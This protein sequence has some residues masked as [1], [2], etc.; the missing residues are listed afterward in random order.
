M[1]N[2]RLINNLTGWAVLLLALIVYTLTLEPTA[3]FWDSGEFIAASYK[4]QIPH[5][6][7]PPFF[8]LL[9][10][11]FS[12]FAFGDVEMIAFCVNMLSATSSAFAVMFLY[13]SIVLV[14][15][16]VLK[17]D[18]KI[19]SGRD[20]FLLIGSGI[21]G[22]LAFA[23]S[24]SFW[25]SA[26]EAEVYALSM[27]FTSIAFWAILR[28]DALKNT[29]AS[30]RWLL[31]IA[32]LMGLSIGV[33][34]MNLLTIPSLALIYYY[35]NY[36]F[37]WKGLAT[38][39]VL[40]GVGLLFVMFGFRVG[41][42]SLLARME[43]FSVN[44]LGLGF[45]SGAFFGIVLLAACVGFGLYYSQKRN[46]AAVNTLILAASFLVIGY[47]SF[48]LLTIRSSKNPLIDMGN[49]ENLPNFISYLDMKQY[50]TR[51]LLH[52]NYFDAKVVEQK[53]DTPVYTKEAKSYEITDYDYELTYDPARTTV[54]PRLWSQR[55]GHPEIYR[56]KLGLRNG[57]KPS[58]TDN[59][60]FLFSYQLGHM[61]M[62]YF[63]W[64]F[65]GRESDVQ[66]A[67]WI[68]PLTS[69]A[70]VVPS[71]RNNHARNNYLMLPLLLGLAGLLFS[72][73]K[74]PQ[75]FSVIGMLFLVTG[76]GLVLY[77]NSPPVEPRERDY[78][79]VGSFFAFSVWIGLGAL[80]VLKSVREYFGEKPM[81]SAVAWMITLFV[82][83]ILISQNWNDHDRSGRYYTTDMAKNHLASCAPNGILFTGGDNDTY[84][85]WY[86][87][88]V[89]GVRTDVRVIVGSLFS[90]DW[91]IEMM[92]RKAYES[93]PL[94]FSIQKDLYKQGGPIDYVPVVEH[95]SLK[96]GAVDLQQYLS[97]LRKKHQAIMVETQAGSVLASIPSRELRIPVNRAEVLEK[98]LVPDTM[99]QFIPDYLSF[100][101]KG[102]GLQKSEVMLLDLIASN[103]WERPI[104]FTFTAL[105]QLPFDLDK[106]VVQEGFT[107]RLLPVENPAN[108]GYLVHT[109]AMYENM[110]EKY[111][112]RNLA[113]PNVNYSTYHHNNVLNPRMG[114]NSLAAALIEEGRP[115]MALEAIHKSLETIPDDTIPYDV[116]AVETAGLLMALDDKD[117][118]MAITKTLVERADADLTFYHHAA[119]RDPFEIERNLFVIDRLHRILKAYGENEEA[120]KADNIFR[121]HYAHFEG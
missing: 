30:A 83:G 98:G 11:M 12:L 32:Y 44:R 101:I 39:L 28:W 103:N 27:F 37:S 8:L 79:Y 99:T 70:D 49:P 78:I 120:L 82:P 104:Y 119:A 90:A 10:R 75:A 55:D 17:T 13:W 65:A 68:T 61:Y 95:P 51:P 110:M 114:F 66:D 15:A 3:S 62:R 36:T 85:L 4:L 86:A 116:S 33:H 5:P 64:N 91:N 108:D 93:E 16:K 38:T 24:D 76:V 29:A 34:P 72:Y 111:S 117:T 109:K 25:F 46:L 31:L 69:T 18:L 121:K 105:N 80:T 102:N 73:K 74:H 47:S 21:T 67:G 106:Y 87:Q 40:S 48:G 43:I 19:V 35:K 56:Q 41:V 107:Y 96:G 58:F 23:F 92:Q 54:F 42:V 100:E 81:V 115:A 89:E 88:D 118:A 53:Q 22:A 45:G 77:L 52:G 20:A 60:R 50:G 57:Q 113:N 9:G 94:P 97:L 2:F 71:M 112:W 6:P 14:A 84:P 26:V 7:G 59:L 63:M 1:P